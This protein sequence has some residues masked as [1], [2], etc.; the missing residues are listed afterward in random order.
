MQPLIELML[1]ELPVVEAIADEFAPPALFAAE[2]PY[3]FC[4]P[5]NMVIVG[6]RSFEIYLSVE[7]K[8]YSNL[9]QDQRCIQKLLQQA[10]TRV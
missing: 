3:N 1:Y 9:Q 10:H 7:K 4:E 2:S 6:Q 5:D 8:Y